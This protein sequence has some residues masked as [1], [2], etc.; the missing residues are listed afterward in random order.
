VYSSVKHSNAI[1]KHY[2]ASHGF[3]VYVS[4]SYVGISRGK[5]SGRSLGRFPVVSP[6][7]DQRIGRRAACLTPTQ[8]GDARPVGVFAV[9]LVTGWSLDRQSPTGSLRNRAAAAVAERLDRKGVIG[10]PSMRPG[11]TRR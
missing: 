3:G 11:L 4:A 9:L 5:P 10:H 2:G 8:R 7:T 6:I 1:D